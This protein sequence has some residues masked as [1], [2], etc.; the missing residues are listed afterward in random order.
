MRNNRKI[1]SKA[2]PCYMYFCFSPGES[3]ND[4]LRDYGIVGR[5]ISIDCSEGQ[6]WPSIRC[7]KVIAVPW[8]AFFWLSAKFVILTRTSVRNGVSL[9]FVFPFLSHNFQ[10]FL[11]VLLLSLLT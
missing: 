7:L 10:M 6:S 8:P 2:S 11:F 3:K 1:S 9:L 5:V 4:D